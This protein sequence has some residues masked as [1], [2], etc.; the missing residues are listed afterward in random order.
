LT[1]AKVKTVA[2]LYK[3]IHSEI[4]K[5]AT[6]VK[7]ATKSNPNRKNHKRDLKTSKDVRRA[8]AV[9]RIEIAKKM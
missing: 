9:K 1:A 6:F 8:N 7:K 2:E 5:N 3:K 4:Y